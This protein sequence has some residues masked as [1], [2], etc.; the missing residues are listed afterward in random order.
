MR[1]SFGAPGDGL[2]LRDTPAPSPDGRQIV[3]AAQDETGKSSLWIRSMD[4]PDPRPIE[5]T[6]GAQRPFWSPDGAF[7][8][9]AVPSQA[10]LKKVDLSR[11]YV[12]NVASMSDAFTGATWNQNGD[13]VFGPDNRVVLL[14]VSASGGSAQPVTVL[15][16]ERREN[17]HRWPHFLPD[18]R[19]FLYTARSDVK[20]NTGIYVGS[21]DSK[22]RTW[23]VE[24]Q[25]SAVYAPPGYLLF[26]REGTLLAQRFDASTLRL[27]GEPV[28][29]AGNVAH[30]P[31]GAEA[32]FAV[33][34]DGSVV[35]FRTGLEVTRELVWFERNGNRRS[36]GIEGPYQQLR[37]A[38]DSNRAAVVMSDRDSGNRDIWMVNLTDRGL[39]RFTSHAANDWQPAWSPD[40]T[41]IAFASD[42][43][44]LST[45]YRKVSNGAAAEELVP[46]GSVAGNIFPDDW[47]RQGELALHVSTPTTLLD[48]WVVSPNA[49][50]RSYPLAQTRFQE[51]TPSFSPDGRW[52]AYVSDESGMPEVYVQAVGQSGK[53]RVS[54]GGG[55]L[56]RW[57]GD[58]R[59]LFFVDGTNRFVAAAVG[60]GDTFTSSAPVLLFNTCLTPAGPD[61]RSYDIAVDGG[62]SLWLC[63][64]PPKA[65]S[66]VNVFV[67]WSSR[68]DQTAH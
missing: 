5:G 46:M 19:H 3:F 44:G 34:A 52:V 14:R 33:G 21:L 6:D 59:E 20:E 60:T 38:P 67:G 4:S 40:G 12:Q 2:Q 27:S 9:F 65:P 7:V 68:L 53:H 30:G 18:G 66:L 36:T 35:A 26:V 23:L 13:I 42:R 64:S 39:T 1:F 55:L 61:Q 16:S 54:T 11:G 22:D 62:R 49:T 8:G 50:A 31:T 10:R 37:L 15:D 32:S 28:A 58:G 24:A 57:R 47:S 43:N 45:V 48:V 51:L 25:S 17:S 41:Q 29:L 56:P 63:P